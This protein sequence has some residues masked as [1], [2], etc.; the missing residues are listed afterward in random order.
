M[1]RNA[2]AKTVHTR[3]SSPPITHPCFYGIDT[4]LREELIA[5][6]HTVDEVGT[7][8]TADSLGYLSLEGLKECVGENS[9]RFCYACFTGDYPVPVLFR[10]ED[11]QLAL[12]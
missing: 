5:S 10:Q 12:F 11:P 9:H 2:G 3:I 8:L 6:T 7:Y 4:P 1:V